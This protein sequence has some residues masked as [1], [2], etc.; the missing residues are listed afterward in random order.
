[1]HC[2]EGKTVLARCCKQKQAIGSYNG[3]RMNTEA[4]IFRIK[5]AA[6]L[7]VE[8]CEQKAA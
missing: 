8:N 2:F 3:L 5:E 1:M 7:L 6:Q 4:L